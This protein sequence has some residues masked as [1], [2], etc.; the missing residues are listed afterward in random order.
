MGAVALTAVLIFW[1]L[2]AL[3]VPGIISAIIA[4]GVAYWIGRIDGNRDWK[5]YH[6][7]SWK[8]SLS[9]ARARANKDA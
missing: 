6:D 1:G 9:E 8:I 5:P 4:A 3:G 2:L 7:A